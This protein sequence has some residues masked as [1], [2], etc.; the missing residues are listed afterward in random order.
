MVRGATAVVKQARVFM[1]LAQFAQPVLVN[2]AVGVVVAPYR[3]LRYVAQFSITGGKI[4]QINVMAD[5]AILR[6][7][8]LSVL[9]G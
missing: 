4:T 8:H 6:Q 1:R 5:P 2:D 3:R 9:P 7:L